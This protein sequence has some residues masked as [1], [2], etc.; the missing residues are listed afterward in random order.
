LGEEGERFS[1]SSKIKYDNASN[2]GGT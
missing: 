2:P 1:N